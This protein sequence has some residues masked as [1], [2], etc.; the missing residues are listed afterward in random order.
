MVGKNGATIA[1]GIV[2]DK[3]YCMEG[4]FRVP[5]AERSA[6]RSKA[7]RRTK[8]PITHPRIF[9]ISFCVAAVSAIA[10]V[11]YLY[12]NTSDLIGSL[13]VTGPISLLILFATW[14]AIL[15]SRGNAQDTDT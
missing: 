15:V 4:G 13:Q 11:L 2:E 3:R 1:P 8:R 12:L 14:F 5:S 10:L 6:E 7:M 9:L